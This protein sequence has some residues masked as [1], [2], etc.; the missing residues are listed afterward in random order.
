MRLYEFNAFG[1]ENLKI[2]DRPDPQPGPGQISIRMK[3]WSLNYRDL[4]LV[5][6]KY[7]PK[8]RLPFTPFSDGTGEV[9]AVGPGVEEFSAG[10]RV[11]GIFMQSWL[12]GDY[13]DAYAR[14]ALGG[15][16]PGILAEVVVVDAA[17]A[18]RIP[19]HLSF[20]EGATLPC[21]G[22]T[23]WNALVTHG[24]LKAG[25]TVLILGSGGVSLF[26]LQFARLMGARIIATTGSDDKMQRLHD[27][28][29]AEVL[30]YKT[31]PEWE[32]KAREA[33]GGRGVDHVVE[34]GGADTLPKSL[35]AVRGG[36]RV[37]VIGN[38]SGLK[39]EINVASILHKV[40]TVQGIYVGSREVFQAMNRG[41]ELAR[42][43]P[44]IDR[45]FPFDEVR[46]ALDH[47]QRGAHF[48]KIAVTAA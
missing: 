25:D 6:G 22:V 7:N 35:A 38:L 48:G 10:D 27:L 32:K 4:L 15:T 36:G 26:S 44:V 21:A 23:A 34:V 39:S 17:G 8:L 28:G 12:A 37:S 16:L 14:S 41:I 11:A 20:E 42:L 13:Q 24:R 43:K 2:V 46:A 30:N 29:A 40:V 1:I 33:T 31:T 45:V 3:A 18:V 47:M 9:L 19:D 5:T